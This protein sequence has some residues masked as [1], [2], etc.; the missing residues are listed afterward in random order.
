MRSVKTPV[1]V[2][3]VLS[4]SRFIVYLSRVRDAV[5]A[6]ELLAAAKRLHPDATHHCFAYVLGPDG[7]AYRSSDDGEP[8]GTAGV[9]MLEAIKK[10]G[11][12][13]VAA[14]VVRYFG[15]VKLGAGGLVRA[16]GGAVRKALSSVEPVEQVVYETYEAMIP[17]T[18]LGVIDHYLRSVAKDVECMYGEHAEVRYRIREKDAAAV[19]ERLARLTSSAVVPA[20]IDAIIDYE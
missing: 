20:R 10:A 5:Q 9:P 7:S 3:S 4:K 1:C 12:T 6:G 15:G 2:E 8:D 19:A 13:D 17:G 11:Y 16:Y 18:S 14:V